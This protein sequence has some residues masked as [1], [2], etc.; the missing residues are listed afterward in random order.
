MLWQCVNVLK[1]EKN[2]VCGRKEKKWKVCTMPRG[3]SRWR[4]VEKGANESR[5]LKDNLWEG[6]NAQAIYLDH[7]GCCALSI[8]L[9]LSWSAHTPSVCGDKTPPELSTAA[10]SNI[11]HALLSSLKLSSATDRNR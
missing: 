3:E 10:H 9:Q 8:P 1:S 6:K 11:Q 4:E 2:G 7:G 5:G